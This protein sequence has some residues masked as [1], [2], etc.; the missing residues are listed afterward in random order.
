MGDPTPE[1]RLPW[2]S[3][4]VFLIVR[5]CLLW[6]VIPMTFVG[7]ILLWPY[8]RRER[9]SLGQ[10]L[11]WADLNLAATLMRSVFRPFVINPPKWTSIERLTEVNHRI[12]FIDPL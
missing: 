11:G 3:A 1:W 2:L 12:S 5:G 9:A 8:W 7:F 10:L 6:V 4:T